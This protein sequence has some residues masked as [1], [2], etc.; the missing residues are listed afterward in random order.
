MS[1]YRLVEDGVDPAVL[2]KTLSLTHPEMRIVLFYLTAVKD[3]DF[4]YGVVMTGQEIAEAMGMNRT[5][6]CKQLPALTA[7]GWLKVAQ[8]HGN[9]TYYGLG[10]AA[11]PSRSNVVPLRRTA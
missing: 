3:P 11:Q 1:A 4:A 5:T 8:R 2:A 7:A 10:P 9:I 6:F